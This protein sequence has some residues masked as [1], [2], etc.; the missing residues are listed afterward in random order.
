MHKRLKSLE[1]IELF[2]DE[3]VGP[4]LVGTIEYE[5][6]GRHEFKGAIIPTTY[7]LFL[8]IA[9]SDDEIKSEDVMYSDITGISRENL[10]MVGN[11]L[12][13]WTG[14]EKTFSL[15]SL[16]DGRLKKF[17]DFLI[18]YR[19]RALNIHKETQMHHGQNAV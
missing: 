18:Q 11:I 14:D 16:S 2:E 7:R 3:V 15:K 19:A 12:H 8:R 10:L 5:Y 1:G 17:L 4:E 9:L 6:D 13:I